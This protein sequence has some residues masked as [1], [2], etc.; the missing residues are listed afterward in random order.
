MTILTV[1]F[2]VLKLAHVIAWSW[3][4]VFAPSLIDFGF[5]IGLVI[6][7]SALNGAF[8]R[9]FS[10]ALMLLGTATVAHAQTTPTLTGYWSAETVGTNQANGQ[11]VHLLAIIR[12]DSSSFISIL[13]TDDGSGILGSTNTTHGFW[14]STSVF[15][16]EALCVRKDT[17][18]SGPCHPY[19]LTD[20]TL[21]WG[22]LTLSRRS[23]E[24]VDPIAP[25]LTRG[26]ATFYPLTPEDTVTTKAP[27]GKIQS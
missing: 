2:V 19:S 20:S 24:Q 25:E 16:V 9:I 22:P 10:L 6:T 3:W 5:F 8:R 18:R 27:T 23:A 26:V 4:L 11:R 1:L 7:A 17:E 14:Q 12:F 13:K 15:G 21:T